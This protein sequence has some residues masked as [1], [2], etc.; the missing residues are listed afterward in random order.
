[1]TVVPVEF[2]VHTALGQD[3]KKNSDKPE[4]SKEALILYAEAAGFQNSKQFDLAGEEWAQFLKK[5]AE[6]PRANEARYNLAVCQLQD[7][8]FKA[9]VDN[10]SAVVEAADDEFERLEDA[11]LNLGWCQ[12]SV[13]LENQPEYFALASATFERLLE[14]Y[15]TGSFR[16][17]ALFFGGESLYL[18]DKFQEAADSYAELVKNHSKSDLHSD[19]MYALGVTREDLRQF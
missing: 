9:A 5:H 12:Y 3:Q 13:A 1:M 2:G 15:P 4:S 8:N 7:K 14:R 19:A 17:Q 16:D 11:Y 10:L 18:Q 6:D